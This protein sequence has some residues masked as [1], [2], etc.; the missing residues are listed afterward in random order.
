MSF[1][2]SSVAYKAW[3]SSTFDSP[4][5]EFLCEEDI[6]VKENRLVEVVEDTYCLIMHVIVG[7]RKQLGQN[8]E[9]LGS[10]IYFADTSEE[11]MEF[12]ASV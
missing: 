5:F 6:Q 10:D 1:S 7:H 8:V 3:R 12:R 11:S 4:S 9:K 2:E